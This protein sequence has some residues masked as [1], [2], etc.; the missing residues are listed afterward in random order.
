MVNTHI[1]KAG[2]GLLGLIFLCGLYGCQ[3][4]A[5]NSKIIATAFNMTTAVQQKIMDRYAPDDVIVQ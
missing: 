2:K 3:S 4:T 1:V 5:Q